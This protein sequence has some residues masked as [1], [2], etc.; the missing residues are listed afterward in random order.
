MRMKIINKILLQQTES[1][2]TRC[3]PYICIQLI[4]WIQRL[5]QEEEKRAN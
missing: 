1:L 5:A 2:D 4:K 3:L